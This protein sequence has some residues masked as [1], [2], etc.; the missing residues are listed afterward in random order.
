MG[1]HQKPDREP[2]ARQSG[3]KKTQPKEAKNEEK[4]KRELGEKGKERRKPSACHGEVLHAT[5]RSILSLSLVDLVLDLVHPVLDVLLK[6]LGGHA[7]LGLAAD[8]DGVGVSVVLFVVERVDVDLDTARQSEREGGQ[9]VREENEKR[10][11]T[12]GVFA[13][14]PVARYGEAVTAAGGGLSGWEKG[15]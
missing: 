3:K 7:T 14:L 4:G 15:E 1:E 8:D 12:Y 9:L 13:G 6:V 10:E 11:G 5:L 2:L